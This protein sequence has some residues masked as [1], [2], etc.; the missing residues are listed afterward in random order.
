MMPVIAL[1][2]PVSFPVLVPFS[3]SFFFFLSMSNNIASHHRIPPQ[4]T[5]FPAPSHHS[6]TQPAG[7]CVCESLSELHLQ[8]HFLRLPHN[9]GDLDGLV[10]R[11]DL[12]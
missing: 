1:I 10:G 7:Q 11:V 5:S 3:V 6:E 4:K 8:R 2:I 12:W 9:V